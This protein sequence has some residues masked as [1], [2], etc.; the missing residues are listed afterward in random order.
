MTSPSPF[1]TNSTSCLSDALYIRS[2]NLATILWPASLMSIALPA[3]ATA[4][5]VK[6][7]SKAA[8][9]CQI[10]KPKGICYDAV[11]EICKYLFKI[12]PLTGPVDEKKSMSFPMV[13]GTLMETAEDTKSNP[14]AMSKGF[15]SGFASATIL[16]KD[17]F[18]CES[19]LNA[20]D[21][22][23][24]TEGFGVEPGSGPEVAPDSGVF[25]TVSGVGEFE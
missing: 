5:T 22:L 2:L 17:D 21:N 11:S 3:L 10:D 12:F 6:R 20:C 7:V 15:R 24:Q 25:E 8:D 23:D 9:A 1:S 16:L 13:K 14:T 19:L 4:P 18:P